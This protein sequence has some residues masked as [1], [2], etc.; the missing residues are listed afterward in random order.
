MLRKYFYV[1]Q[2]ACPTLSVTVSHLLTSHGSI[3]ITCDVEPPIARSTDL[4]LDFT[5]LHLTC[6]V[7]AAVN[8]G[9]NNLICQNVRF[10]FLI[11]ILSKG[12]L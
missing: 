8:N 9:F 4:T 7:N 12:R 11:V 1:A 5:G 10:D 3:L 6:S 2:Q